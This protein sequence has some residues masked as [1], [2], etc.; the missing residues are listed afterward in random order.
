MYNEAIFGM[1]NNVIKY[2]GY[3]TM[4][5]YSSE[6]NVYCGKIEGIDDLITF[7]GDDASKIENEFHKAVNDYIL[8]CEEIGKKSSKP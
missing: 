7:E 8:Y 3:Y 1:V 6:D 4:I 5:N 2:K